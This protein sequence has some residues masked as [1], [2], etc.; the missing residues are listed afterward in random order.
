MKKHSLSA[1]ASIL[2]FSA[3]LIC[4]LASAATPVGRIEKL[5]KNKS[6][7]LLRIDTKAGLA[8]NDKVLVSPNCELSLTKVKNNTAIALAKPCMQKNQLKV[9][10]TLQLGKKAK[11]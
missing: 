8:K 11:R 2:F 1:Q 6:H 9:G 3:I 5:T 7:A 10:S 4:E